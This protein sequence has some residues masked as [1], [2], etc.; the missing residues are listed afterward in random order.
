MFLVD[1]REKGLL[2]ALLTSQLSC[3]DHI[4]E[5]PLILATG[6][7]EVNGIAPSPRESLLV[8]TET[9]L[10]EVRADGNKRQLIDSPIQDISTHPERLIAL[11][12]GAISWGPYPSHDE[13]FEFSQQLSLP[14]ASRIQA[15]FDDQLWISQYQQIIVIDLETQ[16][17]TIHH[18]KC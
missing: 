15:W 3:L 10:W 4:L 1:R 5:A 14:G 7:G 12:A 2:T 9:G 13:E 6:L 17:S 8:A 11:D 16:E 18:E